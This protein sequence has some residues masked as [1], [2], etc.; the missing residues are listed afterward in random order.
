[1]H[2]AVAAEDPEAADYLATLV[3]SNLV[4]G[5][6][7]EVLVNGDQAF[8]AMLDAIAHA[9]KRIS[10]ETFVYEEGQVAN[11]FTDALEKAAQRGVTVY[12][13]LDAV[14]ANSIDIDHVKRLRA[15][16]C[17]IVNFN[18]TSWYTL[19]EVNYR[20]HRKILVVDGTI[21]FT[22]GLG[23]AD[24]W[25]GHAQD[26]DH[27]R[28]THFRIEGPVVA[29]LQ[30]AF[31]EN[32]IEI[33]GRVLHGE[34]YL[35]EHDFQRVHEL[36]ASV[37]RNRRQMNVDETFACA[38][39]VGRTYSGELVAGTANTEHRVRDETDFEFALGDFTH[40]RIDQK[41]HVIIDD[42]DHRHRVAVG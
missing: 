8:P 19:E 36:D 41:R 10:F 6:S 40:H 3:A 30:A 16:G 23:V 11:Q 20:T 15:A 18:P 17:T 7:Y 1:V 22:G 4:A 29:Q 24:H 42:L 28:D 39:G 26:P 14:G 34:A 12:V 9:R 21:G 37:I 25:L 31:M 38:G 32:W 33:T 2:S 13:I 35:A 27:W 5:N